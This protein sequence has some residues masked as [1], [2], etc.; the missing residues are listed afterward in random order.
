MLCALV[1]STPEPEDFADEESDH[2]HT[3]V[4]ANI[5]AETNPI[6]LKNRIGIERENGD[7][8]LSGPPPVVKLSTHKYF[9]WL[10]FPAQV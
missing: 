10:D 4:D 9:Y 5:I 1:P 3:S 8:L 2:R 7:L 6:S